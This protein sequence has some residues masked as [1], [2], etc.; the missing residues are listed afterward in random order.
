MK[1]DEAIQAAIEYEAGVHR[2]Y[3]EAM[4]RAGDETGRRIFE[5]FFSTKDK[6]AGLGLSVVYGLVHQ[7]GGWIDVTSQ[8]GQGAIFRVYLPAVFDP[9]DAPAMARIPVAHAPGS[10]QR[11]LLGPAGFWIP[12]VLGIGPGEKGCHVGNHP[13]CPWSPGAGPGGGGPGL[14]DPPDPLGIRPDERL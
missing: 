12:A 11:L 10:R 3:Q 1:L 8:A 14:H 4:E 6:G 7:R 9:L 5:P 2:T 13:V